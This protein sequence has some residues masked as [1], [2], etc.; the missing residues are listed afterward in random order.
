MATIRIPLSQAD[1]APVS[2]IGRAGIPISGLRVETPDARAMQAPWNALAGLGESLVG[3]ATDMQRNQEEAQRHKAN[4]AT[5]DALSR[6]EEEARTAPP[7]ER[8]QVFR[9]AASREL[10]GLAEGLAPR[11]RARWQEQWGGEVATRGTWLAVQGASEARQSRL[12]ALQLEAFGATR[13]AAEAATPE[14]RDA[15]LAR[16]ES[17]IAGADRDGLLGP[18]AADR[19]RV[20]FQR[21]LERQDARAARE[22][23]RGAG[24]S[25]GRSGRAPALPLPPMEPGSGDGGDG[26]PDVVAVLDP[27]ELA[28]RDDPEAAYASGLLEG[29]DQAEAEEAGVDMQARTAAMDASTA[30]WQAKAAGGDDAQAKAAVDAWGSWMTPLQREAMSQREPAQDNQ[31]ALAELNRNID[32][33]PALAF[34]RGLDAAAARGELTAATYARLLERN[35]AA[36]RADAPALAAQQ[37]REAVTFALDPTYLEEFLGDQPGRIQEQAREAFDAW[38]DANPRATPAQIRQASRDVLRQHQEMRRDAAI[39]RM[40]RVPG[41]GDGPYPAEALDDEEMR[42]FDAMEAGTVE[43]QAAGR[44]LALLNAWRLLGMDDASEPALSAGGGARQG[45][46][47]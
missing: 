38:R 20:Q 25:R 3:V 12:S 13:E 45:G 7:T 2:P 29:L 22:A 27:A 39:P 43:R 35:S 16:M 6:A 47:P 36:L 14:L 19:L 41:L 44:A 23:A 10:E 26:D 18:G 32:T 37:G 17:G 11:V 4:A 46:Q 9:E 42:I 34:R 15:V 1:L 28:R 33:T 5:R 8:G 40:P 24:R 31:A 30:W 21:D